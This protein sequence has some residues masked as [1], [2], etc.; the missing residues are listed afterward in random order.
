[1]TY[2]ITNVRVQVQFKAGKAKHKF[3]LVVVVCQVSLNKTNG[4]CEHHCLEFIVL[5]YCSVVVL[6][7]L[8]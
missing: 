8:E 5:K 7:P 6:M 4:T 3:F 1:M 2:Q